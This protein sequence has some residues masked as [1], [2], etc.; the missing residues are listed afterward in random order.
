MMYGDGVAWSLLMEKLVTVL[1]AYARQQVEA[2]ADVIQIFDSW[3]GQ[4]E[5][6]RLPPYCLG[7][8]RRS[9]SS[10]YRRWVCP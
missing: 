3:A 6:R 8:G 7:P 1:V 2:G 9:W 10:A 5:R 4:A